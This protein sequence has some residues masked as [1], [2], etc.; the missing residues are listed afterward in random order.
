MDLTAFFRLSEYYP[1]E[2]SFLTKE[3][4]FRF[5]ICV[6][7]SA[8]TT[9]KKVNEVAPVLFG[10]YP[11]ADALSK[12]DQKTVEEIIKPLGF[13]SMKARNIIVTA[14]RIKDGIPETMEELVKLPG[15]GRKTASCYLG[16]ILGKPAIIVDT[17]FFRVTKRL[18][19]TDANTP[20]GVEL[21]L[22]KKVEPQYWYRMSMVLNKHGREFCYA[23][24]P[25]CEKCPVKD[26]C[27]S[28]LV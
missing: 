10:K 8:Q 12:A 6:I 16:D 21:D 14:G 3:D 28:A 13:Y 7:L 20:E 1:K 22:K 24:K 2:I 27:P 15:V 5:L 23:K 9:D 17:H 18:G 19:Y 4:P 11:D 26:C 25:D